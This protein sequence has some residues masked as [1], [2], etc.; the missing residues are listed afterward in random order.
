ML[1]ESAQIIAGDA[2]V[3]QPANEISTIMIPAAT[4]KWS[5]IPVR[6]CGRVGLRA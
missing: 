4:I 3:V 1:D 2:A 6:P 5:G